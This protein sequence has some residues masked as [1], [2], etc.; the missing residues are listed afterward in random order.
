MLFGS[1][2]MHAADGLANWSV[3]CIFLLVQ[4]VFRIIGFVSLDLC[5]LYSCFSLFVPL[6]FFYFFLFLLL[7]FPWDK[8]DIVQNKFVHS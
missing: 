7:R 6:D 8:A 2:T 3:L 1:V 5:M 4:I